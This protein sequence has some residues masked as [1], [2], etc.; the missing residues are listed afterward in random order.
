MTKLTVPKQLPDCDVIRE[1]IKKSGARNDTNFDFLGEL[2]RFRQR[3]TDEIR[4]INTLFP[5]YI[6]HDEQYHVK[7][8]FYVAD[9]LLGKGLITAMNSGELFVLSCG[10]YGHDWGMAVSEREKEYIVKGA[11]DKSDNADE[12]WIL[13]DER[14]R[15]KQFA[16]ENTRTEADKWREYVRHTHHLRSG[17]RIR[18]Y[19]DK[20]DLGVADAVARV[21]EGH[22]LDF[23]VLA[24]PDSFPQDFSVMREQVNLRAIAVYLRLVD[25]FDLGDERAPFVIWKFVW[26]RDPLSVM[27]WKKHRSL[28]PATFPEYLSGRIVQIDGST[29]D[30]EVYAALQDLRLYC[31]SQL[32]ECCDILVSRQVIN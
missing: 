13:Q 24:D 27:E 26:P 19:F 29:D 30:H 3:V 32:T 7:N 17:V 9:Q 28:Q 18:R 14:E 12:I 2:I 1:L 10:L 6:P 23:E 15:F 8:L 21:S 5:E 11:N 16:Y 25:L 31:E 22:C 4:Y 20:I